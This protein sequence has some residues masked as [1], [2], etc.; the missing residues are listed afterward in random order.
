MLDV[1]PESRGACIASGVD[2]D[3][4]SSALLLV[5]L[6]P[7]SQSPQQMRFSA[8]WLAGQDDRRSSRPYAYLTKL[9]E[10]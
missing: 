9:C 7:G 3:R 4:A 1:T 8:T 5:L 2:K 6:E 10:N